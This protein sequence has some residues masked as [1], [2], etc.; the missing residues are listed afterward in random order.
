MNCA[1]S[2]Y[3]IIIVENWKGFEQSSKVKDGLLNIS[4]WKNPNSFIESEFNSFRLSRLP[5]NDFII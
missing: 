4:E 2:N 5:W 3:I 1:Q